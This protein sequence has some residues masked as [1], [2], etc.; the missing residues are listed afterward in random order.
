MEVVPVI[1]S[2][3]LLETLGDSVVYQ[4]NAGHA[5]AGERTAHLNPRRLVSIGEHCLLEPEP[6]QR[7]KD[8]GAELDAGTDLAEFRR[9]FQDAHRETFARERVRRRQPPDATTSN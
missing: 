3:G 5:L 4:G 7:P 2:I 9:L 1:D 8:V 6:F